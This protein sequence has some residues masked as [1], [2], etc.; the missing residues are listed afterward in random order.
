MATAACNSPRY[1]ETK[2]L[3]EPTTG[4][5]PE[6]DESLLTYSVSL[7]SVLILSSRHASASQIVYCRSNCMRVIILLVCYL[8]ILKIS[9]LLGLAYKYQSIDGVCYLHRQIRLRSR[10]LEKWN[11]Y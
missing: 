9:R 7:R 1:V 11:Y 3:Q 5:C 4:T 6:P 8:L 10:S 2:S